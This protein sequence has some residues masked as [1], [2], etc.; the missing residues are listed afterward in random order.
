[1]FDSK[2][3]AAFV[4]NILDH[5]SSKFHILIFFLP[6]ITA[7]LIHVHVIIKLTP[8][9]GGGGG[10]KG[11]IF[12]FKDDPKILILHVYVNIYYITKLGNS[13]DCITIYMYRQI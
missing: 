9:R 8:L 10:Q 4:N 13:G 3:V 6:I 12:C 2:T 11:Q 5:R 7:V 1:M